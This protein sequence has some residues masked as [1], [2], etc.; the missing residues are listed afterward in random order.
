MTEKRQFT[1]QIKKKVIGESERTIL[2]PS[3]IILASVP[4]MSEKKLLN[5][6]TQFIQFTGQQIQLKKQ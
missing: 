2:K 1:D 5:L 4:C 3:N 6:L